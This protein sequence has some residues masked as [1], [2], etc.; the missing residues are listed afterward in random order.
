MKLIYKILLTILIIILLILAFQYTRR[1]L[2][3]K[4]M[5]KVIEN[6]NKNNVEYWVDF[7]SLLGFVREQDIIVGDGDGDL[8]VLKRDENFKKAV[9]ELG[10]VEQT[11][12]CHRLFLSFLHLD[13]YHAEV[14]NNMI[15]IPDGGEVPYDLIFPLKKAMIGNLEYSSPG[16]P[17]KLLE[18]RYGKNWRTQKRKLTNLFYDV[19]TFKF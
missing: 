2:L 8:V 3:R 9:D 17:E 16:Q 6:F 1:Y 4:M 19:D 5:F 18:T 14:V 12:G 10:L 13:I 7:G 11:W 15:R